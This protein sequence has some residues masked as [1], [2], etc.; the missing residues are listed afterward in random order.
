[1]VFRSKKNTIVFIGIGT[2]L[3]TRAENI[4]KALTCLSDKK[5]IR[6]EK[7]SSLR[8]TKPAAGP[9]P[10]YLNAVVKITTTLSAR[11]LLKELLGIEAKLG[12]KRLFKNCPRIIDLDILLYGNKKI[13]QPG[14]II[15]HPRMMERDFV[16]KP[17]REIEPEF[18]K[19]V[20][21]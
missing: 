10:D 20:N 11:E 1:M 15:P 7:V 5:E 13:S 12:R 9:G 18:K 14:L 3:G 21:C 4:E 6:I 17:L 2:N 8:E 16:I 19:Y